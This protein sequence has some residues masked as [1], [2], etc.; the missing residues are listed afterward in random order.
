[1]VSAA[2]RLE[3]HRWIQHKEDLS[4]WTGTTVQTARAVVGHVIWSAA[5]E[6]RKT[7][8]CQ[9]LID[10][11]WQMTIMPHSMPDSGHPA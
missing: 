1:M 11:R 3:M 6:H 5:M 4:R 9:S 7:D 8:I 10:G 2:P